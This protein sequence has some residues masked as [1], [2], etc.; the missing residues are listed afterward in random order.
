VNIEKAIE[1]LTYLQ[2]TEYGSAEYDLDIVFDF[3]FDED[4]REAEQDRHRSI[5][6]EAARAAGV[7]VLFE[8]PKKSIVLDDTSDKVIFR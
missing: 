1:F 2:E 6:D 3:W 8:E 5:V 4:S 7:A